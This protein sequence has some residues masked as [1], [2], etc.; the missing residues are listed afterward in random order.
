MPEERLELDVQVTGDFGDLEALGKDLDSV[1]RN[2]REAGSG[3]DHV[4]IDIDIDDISESITQLE[5]LNAELSRLEDKTVNVDVER[6]ITSIGG[7]GGGGT[8]IASGG[9][10]SYDPDKLLSDD[11]VS[12]Q[13]NIFDAMRGNG[14]PVYEHQL[15]PSDISEG[16]PEVP[17]RAPFGQGNRVA[18]ARDTRAGFGQLGFDDGKDIK[19]DLPDLDPEDY[20]PGDDFDPNEMWEGLKDVDIDKRLRRRNMGFDD[21]IFSA[22][23]FHQ[24]IAAIIPLLGI[25]IGAIP[26]AVAAL[27]ALGSAALGAVGALGAIGGLGAMGFSLQE[28][29]EVSMQPIQ[30]RLSEI[31][32]TFFNAFEPLARE[33][34]SVFRYAL[35]SLEQMA[36]PLADA[37]S[38]LTAFTDEFRATVNF[39][40]GAIPGI[41][42]GI[43]GIANA[44]MPVMAEMVSA[45]A[46][47]DILG[48]LAFHLEQ[49]LPSLYALAG[50]LSQIIPAILKISQGFLIMAGALTYVIGVVGRMINTFP[51]LA[52]MIGIV[53]GAFLTLLAAASI[54]NLVSGKTIQRAYML[55]LALRKKVFTAIAKVIPAMD[56][57]TAST[58]GTYFATAALIGVLTAGL[59]VVLPKLLE[60][61]D[62]LG[63]N[64]GEAQSKLEDFVK[65]KQGMRGNI[66]TEV[67]AIGNP[68]GS[69]PY[70]DQST[71]VINAGNRD[72]AARQQYNSSY[73][74][75]QHVDSVFGG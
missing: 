21:L 54:Y 71:T 51:F 27:G 69:N 74:K 19:L 37:A 7:G 14:D 49:A 45:I 38:G 22:R 24:T 10:P 6:G 4:G 17:F 59:G 56:S 39:I 36:R 53:A 75:Q 29:G 2:I 3:V 72:D 11:D 60:H 43:L 12:R 42:S 63:S 47:S 1:D 64:I 18:S 55:A 20:I 34:A 5:A 35:D 26:A 73:E 70:V 68:S 67:G 65:T 8:A 9:H 46:D 13:R 66:G 25:F 52:E 44:A 58:W 16:N 61:F 41:V 28:S 40:E 15:D 32:D 48:V 57:L 33:F 23:S 30:E 62:I 50:G 31:L